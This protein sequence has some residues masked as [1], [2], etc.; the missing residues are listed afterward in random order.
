MPAPAWLVSHCGQYVCWQEAPGGERG[1]VVR[2]DGRLAPLEAECDLRDVGW[3][4][5]VVVWCPV[6]KGQQLLVKVPATPL[7]CSLT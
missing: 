4:P 1:Y 2:H 6:A 3:E 5:A 7:S